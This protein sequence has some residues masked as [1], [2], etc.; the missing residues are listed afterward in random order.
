[1]NSILTV[2]VLGATFACAHDRASLQTPVAVSE[3]Q[4]AISKMAAL[5][6]KVKD[7]EHQVMVLEEKSRQ[8]AFVPTEDRSMPQIPVV[9]LTPV[10]MVD[11]AMDISDAPA[12]VP[13]WVP[14][15]RNTAQPRATAKKAS[16]QTVSK[17][18]DQILQRYRAGDC[19]ETLLEFDSFQK[20]YA[21]SS[22]ADNA[23][24]WMGEC[25]FSSRDYKLAISEYQKLI[26]LYPNENKVADALYRLG[27]CYKAM[28]ATDKA[29]SYFKRVVDEFP[30]AEVQAKALLEMRSVSQGGF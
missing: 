13:D 16:F 5:E 10:G 27:L 8:A 19:Q 23:L 20:K 1:M 14:Q 2:V 9:K 28:A 15:R 11:E 7:L 25:Y 18:Y 24:Y 17:T 6:Q 3:G 12:E 30:G 21:D 29:R 26:K 4:I 22:F